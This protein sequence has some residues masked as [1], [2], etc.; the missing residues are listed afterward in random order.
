[1]ITTLNKTSSLIYE[2]Q[3]EKVGD[4]NLFKFSGRFNDNK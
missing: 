3:L 1:M 4:W 2:I